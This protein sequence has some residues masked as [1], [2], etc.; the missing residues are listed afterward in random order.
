M[1]VR[2][3]LYAS[4]GKL[5]LRI[6]TGNERVPVEIEDNPSQI[7]SEDVIHAG[8]D[9]LNVQYDGLRFG[10][11]RARVAI[12]IRFLE[13]IR[14]RVICAEGSNRTRVDAATGPF[15]DKLPLKCPTFAPDQQEHDQ[16]NGNAATHLTRIRLHLAVYFCLHRGSHPA[17]GGRLASQR[18]QASTAN[19]EA[20]ESDGVFHLS[21]LDKVDL[22]RRNERW[23]T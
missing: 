19:G 16:K 5:V 22:H 12:G 17:K 11:P 23:R 4:E 13:S 8:A 21:T 20:R 18:F 10:P 14:E 9:F 6:V 2:K 1:P 7:F 3:S 15:T